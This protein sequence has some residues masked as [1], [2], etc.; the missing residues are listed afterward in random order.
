MCGATYCHGGQRESIKFMIYGPGEAKQTNTSQQSFTNMCHTHLPSNFPA[1]T[2]FFFLWLWRK[3][4]GNTLSL[5]KITHKLCYTQQSN[6][7][8][9]LKSSFSPLPLF[10]KHFSTCR[11]IPGLHTE[12][13]VCGGTR[14][15]ETAMISVSDDFGW[16]LAHI[17]CVLKSIGETQT[18]SKTT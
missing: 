6:N 14:Q 17:V 11:R 4:K 10:Q 8:V 7:S 1:Y 3:H 15:E 5:F 16:T 9:K 13:E 2:T 18:C 12:A